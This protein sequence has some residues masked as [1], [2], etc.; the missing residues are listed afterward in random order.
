MSA[1]LDEASRSFAV[2]AP[3]SLSTNFYIL[4]GDNAY[5]Y[6]SSL[7]NLTYNIIG[8]IDEYAIHVDSGNSYSFCFRLD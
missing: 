4:V 5:G 8:D 1:S 3:Y 2:D 7:T 6:S